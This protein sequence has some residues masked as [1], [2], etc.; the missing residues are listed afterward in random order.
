MGAVDEDDEDD[1]LAAWPVEGGTTDVFARVLNAI[2]ALDEDDD[3]DE[4]VANAAGG[5]IAGVCNAIHS[6][7][8]QIAL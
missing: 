6:V 1:E 5:G 2:G 8:R 3:G 7:G 4:L